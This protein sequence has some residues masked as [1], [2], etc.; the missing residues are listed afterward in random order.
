VTLNKYD[1]SRDVGA[2]VPFSI[3]PKK[4]AQVLRKIADN[5][6]A[7]EIVGIE[8]FI[9]LSLNRRD[10]FTRTFIRFAFTEKLAGGDA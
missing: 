10:E 8:K 2:E 3:D 1:V 9:V 4:M 5:I 6:D 7:G